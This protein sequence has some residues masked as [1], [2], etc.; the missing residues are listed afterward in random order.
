[1]K[2]V[3][4][5]V[6]GCY[7]EGNLV[8]G[9]KQELS[10]IRSFALSLDNMSDIEKYEAL[11]RFFEFR[12]ED[13]DLIAIANIKVGKD[14]FAKMS[15][16]RTRMETDCLDYSTDRHIPVRVDYICAVGKHF[17]FKNLKCTRAQLKGLI[18]SKEV[19]PVLGFFMPVP[20]HSEDAEPYTQFDTLEN[21][22][23][24]SKD[25]YNRGR[26]LYSFET[27]DTS[28]IIRFILD[29]LKEE[30]ILRGVKAYIK[31]L[32]SEGLTRDT[33]EERKMATRLRSAIDEVDGR[34]KKLGSKKKDK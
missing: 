19:Y 20:E 1:M 2:L 5:E 27:D 9:V 8:E 21:E 7:E 30:D 17:Q 25:S 6:N 16:A 22:L 14:S 13:D 28:S 33:Q 10:A 31:A 11:K 26:S 3:V 4:R 29:R 18:D 32:L 23:N 34:I 24:L 15:R 12:L